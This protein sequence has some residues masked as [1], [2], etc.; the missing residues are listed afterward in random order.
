MTKANTPGK[1]DGAVNIVARNSTSRADRAAWPASSRTGES[2]E[3]IEIFSKHDEFFMEDDLIARS[4]SRQY[5]S[6]IKDWHAHYRA[7]AATTG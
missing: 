1:D 7:V 5:V 4:G 2:T 3:D 6:A